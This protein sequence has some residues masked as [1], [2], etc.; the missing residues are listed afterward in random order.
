L[1]SSAELPWMEL[2]GKGRATVFEK[3]AAPTGSPDLTLM[4]VGAAEL[5]ARDEPAPIAFRTQIT[6]VW[7]DG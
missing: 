6:S 7:G 2:P 1:L 5:L 3:V 4:T